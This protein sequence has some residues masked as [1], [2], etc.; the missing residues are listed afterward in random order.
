MNKV[1]TS[2]HNVF[3]LFTW[4]LTW[5][6]QR[7]PAPALGKHCLYKSNSNQRQAAGGR[8]TTFLPWRARGMHLGGEGR[9]TGQK[10]APFSLIMHKIEA[11]KFWRR[12]KCSQDEEL[13]KTK[14]WKIF[15]NSLGSE[16][17]GKTNTHIHTPHTFLFVE[18]FK[19][20]RKR[21]MAFLLCWMFG[22]YQNLDYGSRV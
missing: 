18:S 12:Q 21:G 20:S 19:C 7:A 17:W 3:L 9:V 4:G 13:S 6:W 10:H 22:F 1:L 11:I 16:H 8:G 5:I 15:R 2:I 14:Y